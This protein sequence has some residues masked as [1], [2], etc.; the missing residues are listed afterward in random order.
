MVWCCAVLCG[1]VWCGVVWCC[2]VVLCGK[3]DD[4]RVFHDSA[5]LMIYV[6]GVSERFSCA[7]SEHQIR[8][9]RIGAAK[10]QAKAQ[11]FCSMQGIEMEKL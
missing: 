9:L 6:S 7:F 8:L 2:D 10:I 1:V 11:L 3:E 5:C 4:R